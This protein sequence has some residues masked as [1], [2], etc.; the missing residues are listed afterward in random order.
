MPISSLVCLNICHAYQVVKMK[1][2]L[3]SQQRYE[4]STDVIRKVNHTPLSPAFSTAN[5]LEKSFKKLNTNLQKL[6]LFF[7]CLLQELAGG[8][9]PSY[10]QGPIVF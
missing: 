5:T 2:L 1:I 6:L 8:S 7:W 9:E 10:S 4:I 3:L